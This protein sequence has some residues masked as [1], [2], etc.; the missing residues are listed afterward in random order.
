MVEMLQWN[1]KDLMIGIEKDTGEN[2][3]MTIKKK[4]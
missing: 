2:V 1:E 3:N 4:H